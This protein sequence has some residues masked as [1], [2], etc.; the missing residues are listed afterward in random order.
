LA[1]LERRQ[2]KAQSAAKGK[3]ADY[4]A[5]LSS[6]ESLRRHLTAGSPARTL[7]QPDQL[8]S[9]HELGLLTAKPML[10]V[11]NVAEDDLPAGGRLVA[12]LRCLADREGTELVMICAQCEA[13]LTDW[14]PEDAL[15]YLR[16]LGLQMPGLDRFIRAGY[17][18]LNLITFFTTTGGEEVRAWPIRAGTSVLEAA[19]HI[20]TDMRRGFVRA[21]V[22]ACGDLVRAGSVVSA[23][24]NGLVHVE[25]KNYVVQDGDVIHVRFNV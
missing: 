2:E 16:E 10:Y 15:S 23:R 8:A 7:A 24:E 13:E 12:S 21:E 19:G 5:M 20:H 9:A 3:P 1:T 11:A 14:P 18:L 22:V 6:L 17:R 25:G 4:A